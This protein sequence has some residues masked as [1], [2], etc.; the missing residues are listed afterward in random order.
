MKKFFRL[1]VALLLIGGWSLAALSLHAIVAP[2]SPAR[3]ILV[4][5]NHLGIADTYVDTRHWTVG[6]V[7]SILRSRSG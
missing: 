1:L 6:D 5:K 7:R 4:P 3:V 2:G